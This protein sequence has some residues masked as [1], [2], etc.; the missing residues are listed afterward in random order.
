MAL[1]SGFCGSWPLVSA[2]EFGSTNSSIL[3]PCMTYW[4]MAYSVLVGNCFG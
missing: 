1:A 3:P 2:P 4:S